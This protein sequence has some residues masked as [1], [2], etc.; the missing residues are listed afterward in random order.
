[1]CA[2]ALGQQNY[3][4]HYWQERDSHH[5]DAVLPSRAEVARLN[6]DNASTIA[7]GRILTQPKDHSCWF[8]SMSKELQHLRLKPAGFDQRQLRQELSQLMLKKGAGAIPVGQ[9]GLTQETLQQHLKPKT[10]RQQAQLILIEGHQ[11]G[12]GGSP[13]AALLTFA[14]SLL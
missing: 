14:V 3:C 8:H 4:P 13:E 1:M 7:T 6:A 9:P 11:K 2:F 12:W 10:L 5:P